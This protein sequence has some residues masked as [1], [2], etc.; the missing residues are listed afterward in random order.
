MRNSGSSMQYVCIYAT[1]CGVTSL[2]AL[3]GTMEHMNVAKSAKNLSG[4]SLNVNNEAGSAT[5]AVQ[6][7]ADMDS[8]WKAIDAK[9]QLV[10]QN[11]SVEVPSFG[12]RVTDWD[13]RQP[14]NRHNKILLVSSSHAQECENA[15]GDHVLLKSLKNKVDYCRVHGVELYY[16]M[17]QLDE[18]LA[19]WWV[20]L[21]VIHMLMLA[22]PDVEW[23]LWMDSDAIFTN[24]TFEFPLEKYKDHNMVV[25]GYDN[26]LYEEKNWLGLNTGQ[27]VKTILGTTIACFPPP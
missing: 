18:K 20:K 6:T 11:S 25:Q 14:P 15:H 26:M 2:L 4:S 13:K 5:T 22:R 24:M 23:I 10:L 16:N 1:V 3:Y 8:R 12:P 17:D 21:F 9:M 19:G 27:S 7:A